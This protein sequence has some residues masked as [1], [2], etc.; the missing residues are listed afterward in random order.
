MGI[1]D[2]YVCKGNID[3]GTLYNDDLLWKLKYMD[4]KAIL[5]MVSS[6]MISGTNIYSQSQHLAKQI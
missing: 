2:L 6:T 5:M 3:G 4:L 1:T